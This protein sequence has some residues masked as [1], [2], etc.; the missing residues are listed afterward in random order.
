[1]ERPHANSSW[2]LL[3]TS[4][5]LEF[6]MDSIQEQEASNVCFMLTKLP[7]A[8]PWS[9]LSFVLLIIPSI[10]GLVLVLV[11][12]LI[13]VVA[14]EKMKLLP[15]RRFLPSSSPHFFR[16]I[17][18]VLVNRGPR[19][20]YSSDCFYLFILSWFHVTPW[21]ELF[22]EVDTWRG[23]SVLWSLNASDAM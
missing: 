5:L 8:A 17:L 2:F 1:M 3:T 10:L 15:S 20:E 12:I 21:M 14:G 7:F 18:S 11:L 6:R 4:S 13:L 9:P 23:S 22:H 16:I 19:G